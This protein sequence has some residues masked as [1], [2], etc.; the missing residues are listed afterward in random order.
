MGGWRAKNNVY[1]LWL[2]YSSSDATTCLVQEPERAWKT[3]SVTSVSMIFPTKKRENIKSAFIHILID[4]PS[5]SRETQQ[6]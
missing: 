5:I 1:V 2:G 4:R 3:R 6:I